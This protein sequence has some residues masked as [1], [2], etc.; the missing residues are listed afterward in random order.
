M[1]S[2]NAVKNG[3]E[4]RVLWLIGRFGA[5]VEDGCGIGLENRIRMIRNL[6]EGGVIVES[7]GRRFALDR[8]SAYAVKVEVPV[9]NMCG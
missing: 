8:S 9:Q 4:C 7:G 1:R 5:L 6:G 3:T 2:L